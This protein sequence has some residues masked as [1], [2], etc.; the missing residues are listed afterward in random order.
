MLTE[1]DKKTSKMAKPLFKCDAGGAM[2]KKQT[3]KKH[4]NSKHEEQ[5]CKVCHVRFKT[6]ME[7]LQHVAKDHSN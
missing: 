6:S 4:Y 1:P 5:A 2:F 7:V 3:I